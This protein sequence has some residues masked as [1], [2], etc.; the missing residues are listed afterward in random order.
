MCG[1][2]KA[3]QVS[4]QQMQVNPEKSAVWIKNYYNSSH[5]RVSIYLWDI[6]VCLVSN[7][8]IMQKLKFSYQRKHIL[9]NELRTFSQGL[10]FLLYVWN[11]TETNGPIILIG[12]F[13]IRAFFFVLW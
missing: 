11:P 7:D 12:S 2:E 10:A 4:K 5:I 1:E 9:L 6:Y 3:S 13:G 8:V